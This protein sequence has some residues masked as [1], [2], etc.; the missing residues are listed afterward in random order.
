MYKV[1]KQQKPVTWNNTDNGYR[2][3]C[4]TVGINPDDVKIEIVDDGIHLTGTT[5]VDDEEYSVSY[6]MPVSSMIMNKIEDIKYESK[7]GLT[8]IYLNLKKIE[9][10]QIAISKM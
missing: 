3:I 8:Y 5:I 2:A 1:I 9:K 4:R 10:K 6:I 7:N